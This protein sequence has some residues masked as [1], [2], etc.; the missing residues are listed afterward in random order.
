MPQESPHNVRPSGFAHARCFN[1]AERE[2][3]ARCPGCRRFFCR[4]CVSEHK[5]RFLCAACLGAERTGNGE[6][7]GEGRFR[8]L[9]TRAFYLAA[10]LVMLW[11]A[12]LLTGKALLALP[13]EFHGSAP[14]A[15]QSSG[16][17]LQ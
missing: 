1:H 5:H 11:L 7:H 10:A 12:F 13:D 2:A 6:R 8:V 9:F 17:T 3:A 14:G 15:R 16:D 4:E